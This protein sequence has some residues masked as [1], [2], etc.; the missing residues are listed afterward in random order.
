MHIEEG[1]DLILTQIAQMAGPSKKA[2]ISKG[3]EGDDI[4]MFRGDI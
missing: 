3:F 4:F 1:T 2:D